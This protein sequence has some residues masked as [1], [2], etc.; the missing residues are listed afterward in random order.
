MQSEADVRGRIADMLEAIEAIEVAI[1]GHDA[2]TF[3]ADRKAGD[4]VLW[5][6]TKLGEAVRGV[7]NEVQADNPEISWAKMRG[8]RNLL[9]HECFRVDDQIV[10][11]TATPSPGGSP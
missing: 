3:S 11:A 6:L 4:A 8:M 1:H 10:W 9:V 5:N 7:P 2:A